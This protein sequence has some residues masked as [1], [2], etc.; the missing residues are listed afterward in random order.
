[1]E[2]LEAAKRLLKPDGVFIVKFQV[3]TPWIAGRL[4]DLLV[5]VFNHEPVQLQND[6]S[7]YTTGG[8][9]FIT[10]SQERISQSM[11]N[12][13]LARY[14]AQHANLP[15]EPASPTTDDWPYFYQRSRGLPIPVVVISAVLIFLCIML[16]RDMGTPVR[17]I[18]WH[19]FFLGAGFMLLE[20]QIISKVALLFGTTWLVNSIVIGA[21]LLLILAANAL[22]GMK[23]D[24]S[25][26]AAYV[27]LLITLILGFLVPVRAIFFPS[28]ATRILVA[29][30]LLCIPVFFAGIVFIRSFAQVGYASEALGSNLLGAMVGGMLESLSLWTGIRSL[31]L[32]AAALY[33]ASWV[34]VGTRESTRKMVVQAA[35]GD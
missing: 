15:T 24:F 18:G 23:P 9:F 33:L 10:G 27:G 32:I 3:E 4:H 25:V 34:F 11:N 12:P 22:T 35:S 31:A 16:L 19:F 8:R 7:A 13:A 21:L 28:I 26:T 2:A 30:L 20:A 5:E 6:A 17:S 1:V 29:V 14:V